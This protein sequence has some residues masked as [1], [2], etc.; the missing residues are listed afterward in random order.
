MISRRLV[1]V[2]LC[3]P[4]VSG[5][6]PTIRAQEVALFA[7]VPLAPAPEAAGPWLVSLASAR[8]A[9]DLGFAAA[10]AAQAEQLIDRSDTPAAERDALARLLAAA[11][12]EQGRPEAA[13]AALARH[14]TDSPPARRLLAG[15]IAARLGQLDAARVEFASLNPADL[16]PAEQPWYHFLEGQLAEAAR[17]NARAAQAYEQASRLVVSEWQAARL[18]IARERLRLRLGEATP[19]QARELR[20]QADR[21]AGRSVGVDF[22]AQHAVALHQLGLASEGTAYLQEQIALLPDSMARGRDDLRL[23]LALV[24]GPSQPAGRAAAEQL[25]LSAADPARRPPA[26]LLLAASADTPDARLR[27]RRTLDDLLAREPAGDLAP[28]ALVARAE[29]ALSDRDHAPAEADARAVIDRF[30]ASPLRAR[31]LSQLAAVAWELR[32]F[33]TAADF[34]A[35]A[36][37][38]AVADPELA[39]AL[40]LLSA[41]ASFRARDY[42]TAAQAYALAADTPPTGVPR[43]A[44]R[45]QEI[46]SH[47]EASRLDEAATVLDR[48]ATTLDAVT[49]WQAEWNLA[50]ALQAA[51]RIAQAAERITRLAATPDKSA[52]PPALRARLDWLG[53][54]LALASGQANEALA[55]ARMLR[56]TLSDVPMALAREL[57][58]LARI[59]EAEALFASGDS[60]QAVAALALARERDGGAEAA[61]QSY[62]VE[63]DFQAAAG[64]L[65]KAQ[66]LLTAFADD[67]ATHPYAPI[68][69]YQ[70]ALHAARRG[71]E[72]VYRDAYLLLERLLAA[73]PRHELAFAARLKQG[74]LLRLLNQFPQAQQIYELLINRDAQHPDILAAR[75]ALAD[76]HRAQAAFDPAHF[77][78]A[79]TLLERLRDLTEAPLARRAEAGF[80]LGDM[81]S[82]RDASAALAAWDATAD[83]L[84]TAAAGS[85][86]DPGS[87]YWLGRTLLRM[88]G[89]HEQA[90][91]EDEARRRWR[92]VLDLDLPGRAL[93]TERLGAPAESPAPASN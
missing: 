3:L 39:A 75:M 30:P 20:E 15:L 32:R 71:E 16:A 74:D 22:A 37:V 46:L 61:V 57:S 53:I 48:H 52:L 65:V 77:E 44:V 50:R 84:I 54:R 7:P 24:A 2:L 58:G 89:L 1:L 82:G 76:C 49:R 31:A 14:G 21:Y 8:R 72:R 5:A 63:A 81:L 62:L 43:A 40:R 83:P 10:A 36:A 51:G 19:Q 6:V 33:R 70:A 90:G 93:A 67:H 86:L 27:L 60:A 80:K 25:L 45:F 91:E 78:S 59:A 68:A 11:R 56:D 42:Q 4:L 41:E 34:A 64:D 18:R 12:L 38:A 35:Q 88:A 87:R 17:D 85:G 69:L 55:K 28:L 29:L 47:I 73:Y 13:A 26:L 92:L 66:E 23:V 9:L 79:I